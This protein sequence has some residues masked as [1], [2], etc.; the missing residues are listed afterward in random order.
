MG[1]KT[2]VSTAQ[3]EFENARSKKMAITAPIDKKP[4]KMFTELIQL[5]NSPKIIVF[6]NNTISEKAITQIAAKVVLEA[7]LKI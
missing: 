4:K 7:W 3:R 1:E 2:I 5:N 6:T